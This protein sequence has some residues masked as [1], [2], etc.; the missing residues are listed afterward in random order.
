MTDTGTLLAA[1]LFLA[2]AAHRAV[3]VWRGAD[4][5]QR[6]I[7]GFAGCMG[8]AMLFRAPVVVSALHHV[9]PLDTV[10]MLITHELKT[11]AHALLLFV[12]LSLKPRG[13]AR[14]SVRRQTALAITV[15]LASGAILLAAGVRVES[16]LA[17][18]PEDRRWLLASY[19]VLF[20]AY[21]SWC[22]L[23]LVREL[24]GHARQ[25]TAGALRTGLR[26]MTL[27]ALVGT[28]W[29]LWVLTYVPTNLTQGYQLPSEDG[30]CGA[31]GALTAVL[32]VAGAT[33][34]WWAALPEGPLG[35]PGRWLFAYRT[36][37]A[38]EPLWTALRTELPQIALDPFDAGRR[39]PLRRAEFALYRRVIEIRDGH[40]ALRPYIPTDVPGWAAGT[41]DRGADHRAVLEAAIIAAALESKRAGHR[42]TGPHLPDPQPHPVAGT[43]AAEAAWLL[44]VTTAFVSSPTVA[45][46]RH[47]ARTACAAAHEHHPT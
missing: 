12:A 20:A 19:N 37:R 16:G 18:A 45:A 17:A 47:R 22:L 28:V 27:A 46:V 3:T 44:Q 23:V 34:T 39:P 1:A 14:G 30:V 5:A 36:H 8:T 6:Y 33:A 29:T 31:L 35:A 26:L 25:V 11:C 2:F 7:A 41:T 21:G 24:L 32:A 43:L 42:H 10:I 4:T 40:L 38:L 9:P 15:L 13:P